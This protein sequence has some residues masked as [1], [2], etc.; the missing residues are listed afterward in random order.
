MDRD[1]PPPRPTISGSRRSSQLPLQ[2]SP[3]HCGRIPPGFAIVLWLIAS[4][5]FLLPFSLLISLSSHLIKPHVALTVQS[6]VYSA[7]E[8]L[9]LPFSQTAAP[10]VISPPKLTTQPAGGLPSWREVVMAVWLC[11]F[12]ATLGLWCW[13]WC[14][15]ASC[16]RGAVPMA[17][18]REFDALRQLERTRASH[19]PL[20]VFLSAEFGEPGVFGIFRPVLL[21]PA[22]ISKHLQGTHVEAILAHEL[23]HVQRH[24]NLTAAMHMLVEAIF[25]FHP[26]VWWLG[27]QMAEERE[28]ACDE[29][30]LE[31]GKSAQV[32]AESILKTLRILRCI[33]A[34]L[35]FG[36]YGRRSQETYSP[37]HDRGRPC[38]A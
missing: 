15:V 16:L 5:K 12:A 32:Y 2:H 24:D 30:V 21:W 33:A 27:A 23:A 7:V 22:G 18:G 14:S 28:R 36:S 17:Q 13:R 11:G 6:E 3:W 8:E 29:E 38:S 26:G 19:Q 34:G 25:W 1:R 10:V 35:Y 4:L 31:L 20:A 37:H 9:S